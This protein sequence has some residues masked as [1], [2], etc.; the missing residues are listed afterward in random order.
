MSFYRLIPKKEHE[1]LRKLIECSP[2]AATVVANPLDSLLITRPEHE[3]AKRAIKRDPD[4]EV[5]KEIME[6][7]RSIHNG[8]LVDLLAKSRNIDEIVT[9]RL[10]QET[11]EHY[12]N[13]RLIKSSVRIGG[14]FGL[15]LVLETASA[16]MSAGA[17]PPGLSSLLGIA[18]EEAFF[19]KQL[20]HIGHHLAKKWVFKDKGLPSV[21]WETSRDSD[22]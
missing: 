10:N 1:E 14:T 22:K 19:G 12:R 5:K 15:D 2:A 16:T 20:D 11:R 6:L 17:I 8:N 18:V 4:I 7:Q 3:E 21:F 13:S 9:E